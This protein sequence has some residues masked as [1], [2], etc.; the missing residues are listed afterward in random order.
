MLKLMMV[1]DPSNV[2]TSILLQ[3][4]LLW[5]NLTV[6][7]RFL[8]IWAESKKMLSFWF[9]CAPCLQYSWPGS[10]RTWEVSITNWYCAKF[11]KSFHWQQHINVK[12]KKH[13]TCKKNSSPKETF[14]GYGCGVHGYRQPVVLS[15][16]RSLF[17]R[18]PLL[19]R[20]Q[21]LSFIHWLFRQNVDMPVFFLWTVP[22]RIL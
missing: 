8:P 10:K 13:A 6:H 18:S 22:L 3:M 5:V 17:P 12:C 11:W 14:F 15:C 7:M 21:N 16:I 20:E 19:R 4:V 2:I 1:I 9:V